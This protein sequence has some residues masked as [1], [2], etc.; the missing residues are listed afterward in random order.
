MTTML[1]ALILSAFQVVLL[2]QIVCSLAHVDPVGENFVSLRVFLAGRTSVS[3]ILEAT[4]SAVDV[5]TWEILRD[6][7]NWCNLSP[8]QCRL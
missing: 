7:L 2:R 8:L 3:S 4:R 5:S 1:L 6:V